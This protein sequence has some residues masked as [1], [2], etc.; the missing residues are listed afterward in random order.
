MRTYNTENSGYLVQRGNG[1]NRRTIQAFFLFLMIFV[2]G[3]CITGFAKVETNPTTHEKYFT[4]IT[5]GEGDSLWTIAQ[6]NRTE[7]YDSIE[8]Y[9]DEVKS[10]NH[11]ED[12][13]ITAGRHIVIPHYTSD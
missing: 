9:I 13:V 8:E 10:I 4:S 6:A 7:E 2:F 1:Q 12:D 11:L 3:I 5:I